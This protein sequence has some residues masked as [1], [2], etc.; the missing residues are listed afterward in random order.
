M[1][2]EVP[3]AERAAQR[4]LAAHGVHRVDEAND[5]GTQRRIGPIVVVASSS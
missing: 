2:S 4:Q 5:P 3:L 1:T